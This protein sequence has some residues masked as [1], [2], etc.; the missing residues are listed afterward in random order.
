MFLL[1]DNHFKEI[2]EL[3]DCGQRVFVNKE[4]GEILYHPDFDK[5]GNDTEEYYDEV[6]QELEN[7]FS[8]YWEVEQLSTRES[9]KIMEE[10]SDLLSDNNH[11][12]TRLIKALNNK[13]PFMNFK[14]EI[15]NSG[16]YREEWFGFK[17]EKL[18]NRVIELYE[19]EKQNH[20][21][22]LE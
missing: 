11:L 6:L 13:K 22:S 21:R 7:N 14:F 9:F 15:D 20:E 10:F 3:L 5:Y 19:W 4:T 8:D 16:I 2:A 17:N 12:K 18:K 1:L